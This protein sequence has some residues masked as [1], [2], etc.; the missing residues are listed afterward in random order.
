MF[1]LRFI[2]AQ[3][4][5]Y[6]MKYRRGA[7]TQQGAGLSGFYYGPVTS[8][9]AVPIGSRDAAFI[10]QQIARDFQ[11]LTIQGHVTYRISEPQKAAAMLN[12]TLKADG[13]TYESDDPEQLP[14]RILAT[15][16]VL[17]QQAVKELP[18]KEAL[19]AA[20][21][22]AGLIES[23]LRARADI[24]ALGLEI[25]GVSIRGVKP[26]PDTAKAL[27]AEAREAIL[28]SADEAIF[29]RRNFAVE[30]ERAIRESELDTEI[31]VE[32]KKRSIRETQMDAEASVAAKQAEL[33]E[34][35]MVADITLESKRKD[36]VGLNAENTRTLAD[37]EAYRVGA[38]MK[39]FEGVDTRV[40]QALAAAGMQPG[41]LIA[42]A[43]SGIAEKAEKI[44]QLNVSPDLLNTLLD[45]PVV[46]APRARRQ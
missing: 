37:A 10:F 29:A 8:L 1:G 20:N 31:A 14:Q 35:G 12:F 13:K 41:Q 36:F 34:A 17:A 39:I 9:V 6:L 46:E 45:R 22:I 19:Q 4:T 24:A 2:K 21:R 30:Q 40:I 42:Q 16:E 44:G 7:A 18:L 15:V 43:F 5:T 3:P 33:R 27:E 28:K 26:T 25:L 23:G 11:A 38:L 32:Q